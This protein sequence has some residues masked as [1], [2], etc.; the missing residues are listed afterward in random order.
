[1]LDVG[2]IGGIDC[3]QR[4]GET[5]RNPYSLDVGW[6]EP[7]KTAVMPIISRRNPYSLDVGWIVNGQTYVCRHVCVAIPIRWMWAG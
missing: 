5:R 7:R 2:W 4:V 6:I 1:S 3:R